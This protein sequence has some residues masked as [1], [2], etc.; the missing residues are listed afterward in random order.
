MTTTGTIEFTPYHS[1]IPSW[2]GYQYQGKVALNVV[3]DYILKI[4]PADYDNYQLELEWYEDFCILNGGDYVSIHQVKSYKAHTLSEYKDAIWNLLGKTLLNSCDECYLHSTTEIESEESIKKRL[5]KLDPPPTPKEPKDPPKSPKIKNYSPWHYFNMVT[6]SGAYEESFAKFSKYTY[7]ASKSYCPLSELESEIFDR[8]KQYYGKKG[9]HYTQLQL[10]VVYHYLL[11]E[12]DK[13]ITRRH[14]KEQSESEDGDVQIPDRIS[15]RKIIEVLECNWEEP[16]EEYVILQLRREFHSIC[17]K[18]S[19]E[20]LLNMKEDQ[21]MSGLEDLYKVEE[22][23]RTIGSLNNHEFFTFCQMVTPHIHINKANDEAYRKLVPES[24]IVV[25]VTA[26][27]EIK[28]KMNSNEYK[29]IVQDQSKNTVYLPTTLKLDVGKIRR[30]EDRL[31][32]AIASEILSNAAIRNN[33][34]EIE[35]MITENFNSESL[36][37]AAN[38]FTDI[39]DDADAKSDDKITKIKRIRLIDI[40]TAKGEL[41]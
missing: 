5:L 4:S 21:D 11:G 25:L 7:S 16:S 39:D 24:G 36:V 31:K 20:L 41:N 8:L 3:L 30:N 15:F 10:D 19:E 35:V 27:Y 14:I 2:S 23:I 18:L 9:S 29:Y 12:V 22:Y 6:S 34:Y 32:S 17:D 38:K 13:N 37:Q 40:N 1:A 26:F 28:Q 33:L